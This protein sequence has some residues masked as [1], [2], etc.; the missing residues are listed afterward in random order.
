MAFPSDPSSCRQGSCVVSVNVGSPRTV[1]WHGERVTSGIWKSPV[2][3]RVAVR[4]V[5]LAGDD[6]ADRTVHGGPD[7]A[8]YAYAIED[9]DWWAGE[10]GRRLEP[11]TFGEN[12]TVRGL[13][14]TNVLV[15]ERW[16]IGSVL[17]EVAQ[18]RLP[19]Y[20]L[21]MRMSDAGFPLRFSAAGRP[22]AYLRILE[23]GELAAGDRIDVVHRPDHDL[24]VG[25]IARIYLRDRRQVYR[26][27]EVAELPE[28]W[29]Q[30]A[31]EYA[32][33]RA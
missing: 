22:G 6:Q 5:N 14:V 33:K 9:Y 19:C 26:M 15:G 7:K 13:A 18:P 16:R 25:D 21:G 4:G 28:S 32:A 30:W 31:R 11:A 20:K 27:L 8:V 12:L 10:L 1:D 3:G 24:T 23:E 29:Q 17:L 2:S